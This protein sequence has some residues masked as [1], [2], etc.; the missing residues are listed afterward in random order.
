[1]EILPSPD[2]SNTF[3]TT[4]SVTVSAGTSMLEAEILLMAKV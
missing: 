1:M 4:V 2:G 3:Q